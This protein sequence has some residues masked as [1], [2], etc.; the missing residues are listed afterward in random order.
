MEK[1]QVVNPN[2]TC[3]TSNGLT[4]LQAYS[5]FFFL[6][7]FI[8]LFIFFFVGC[9]E[10][11]NRRITEE[12]VSPWLSSYSRTREYASI[13]DLSIDIII[14]GWHHQIGW[15]WG[16]DSYFILKLP[17]NCL[18]I[19]KCREPNFSDFFRAFHLKAHILLIFFS[20]AKPHKENE[21]WIGQGPGM[22]RFY[23]MG[24]NSLVHPP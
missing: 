19:K 15:R 22:V 11:A 20:S 12:P 7:S 6:F 2:N 18:P 4:N 8:Y 1:V 21:T 9:E 3:Q 24:E 5:H 14:S 10:K 17:D 16:L 23:L 13:S